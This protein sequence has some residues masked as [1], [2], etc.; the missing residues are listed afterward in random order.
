LL[1]QTTSIK[2]PDIGPLDTQRSTTIRLDRYLRGG[3]GGLYWWMATA[4]P[5]F[6]Q[7]RNPAKLFTFVAFGI[8]VLAGMGWDNLQEHPGRCRGTLALTSLPLAAGVAL[9][10]TVLAQRQPLVAALEGRGVSGNFGPLDARTGVGELIR[11]LIHGSVTQALAIVLILLARRRVAIAGLLALV[12]VSADLAIANARLVTT[13]PQSLFES[14]PEVLRII[15]EAERESPSPGPFRVHRMSQWSPPGW[16]SRSSLDREN[17][18]LPWERETIRPKVGI[19]QGIEYTHT[20][21][22][23]ELSSVVSQKC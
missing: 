6:R 1:A 12:L 7:F 17:E 22:V 16:L 8:A 23:S 3:D 2:V 20:K 5:G 9:L 10:V 4:L 11:G 15:K 19:T 13:V 14:E 18:F 21:G